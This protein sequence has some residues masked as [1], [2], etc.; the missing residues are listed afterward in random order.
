MKN[1]LFKQEI[2][3]RKA[4]DFDFFYYNEFKKKVRL[5]GKD[6]Y[7]LNSKNILEIYTLKSDSDT[8]KMREEIKQG[9]I[10]VPTQNI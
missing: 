5:V 9:K 6:F 10:Y 8:V 3:F 7:V 1:T 4:F 2:T